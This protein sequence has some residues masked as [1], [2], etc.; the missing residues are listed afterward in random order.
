[1]RQY[2]RLLEN[3]A[4]NEETVNDCIFT[5][6]HHIAGDLRAVNVLL[7]PQILRVFLKIWKEGFELC[8]VRVLTSI[9][10]IHFFLNCYLY[11]FVFGK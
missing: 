3:F 7:Q 4:T 1:M 5:I 6:M 2:G 9:I 10:E 8:I 11:I